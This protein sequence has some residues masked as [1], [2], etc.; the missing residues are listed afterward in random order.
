ML[1]RVIERCVKRTGSGISNAVWPEKAK[2]IKVTQHS[3]NFNIL[4]TFHLRH[5]D[6]YT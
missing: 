4:I 3:A 2:G 6:I 5:L 1:R